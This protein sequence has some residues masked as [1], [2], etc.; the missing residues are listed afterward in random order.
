MAFEI[1]RVTD[2]TPYNETDGP[3]GGGYYTCPQQNCG[4][5]Q[6]ISKTEIG[7]VVRCDDCNTRHKFVGGKD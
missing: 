4:K 3:C 1:D 7:Q 2:M 5:Q 6:Y